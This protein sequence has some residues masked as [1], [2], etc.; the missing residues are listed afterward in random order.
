METKAPSEM[1]AIARSSDPKKMVEVITMPTP[2][3]EKGEVLIRVEAC[4]INPSD[5]NFAIGTYG[6]KGEL[7]IKPPIVP[8]FEG[9]GVVVALGEGAPSALLNQRVGFATNPHGKDKWNGSWAQYVVINHQACIPIGDLSFEDTCGLVV[10]PVT[11]MGFLL[12]VKNLNSKGLVHTAAASSLGKMLVKICLKNNVELINVVRRDA[13]ADE[14]KKLG[15]KHILNQTAP[16]FVEQLSELTHKLGITVCFDAISGP[17]VGKL[18]AGM[19]DKSTVFV[20]GALDHSA[21]SGIMP[22]DLIFNGKILKGYWM[23]TGDVSKPEEF[24]KAL[25]FIIGDM[26]SGNDT[27]KPKIAKKIKM[28]ECSN[29][30]VD[31][32]NHPTEGKTLILPNA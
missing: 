30:L 29:Y 26:K 14:L 11:A 20:Y 4:P 24:V 2:K 31:H 23:S 1:K 32:K 19:P 22:Q 3:P 16:D 13:Q 7:H 6:K 27:F 10:N 18:M 28:E 15:A 21:V 5:E 8:G 17:I 9:S 12:E 25:T